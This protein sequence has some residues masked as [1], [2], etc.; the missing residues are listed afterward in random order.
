[1]KDILKHKIGYFVSVKYTDIFCDLLRNIKEII[2]EEE[3]KK[4]E[5]FFERYYK[6]NTTETL[7]DKIQLYITKIK[8]GIFT[9][10]K[11]LNYTFSIL[12]IKYLKNK[13]KKIRKKIKLLSLELNKKT[14][15]LIE[16]YIRNCKKGLK[17]LLNPEQKTKNRKLSRNKESDDDDEFEEHENINLFIGKFDYKKFLEQLQTIKFKQSGSV[18]AFIFQDSN[19]GSYEN[20]LQT[21]NAPSQEYKKKLYKQRTLLMERKKEKILI[22]LNKKSHNL[23]NDNNKEDSINNNRFLKSKNKTSRNNFKLNYTNYTSREE[24]KNSNLDSYINSKRKIKMNKSEITDSKT[25]LNYL[26]KIRI[27]KPYLNL[28]KGPCQIDFF[29]KKEDLYY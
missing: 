9:E 23:T 29:L 18:H 22:K 25:E 7:K 24:L 8:K 2:K 5:T 3:D 16:L 13:A 10:E 17:L 12:E 26:P 27:K 19:S 6:E 20:R 11:Y 28:T 15:I 14:S 1:M 21:F 4:F